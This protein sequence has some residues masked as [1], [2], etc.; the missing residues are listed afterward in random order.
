MRVNSTPNL[1]LCTLIQKITH[2]KTSKS[3]CFGAGF[4]KN[5]QK[6]VEKNIRN[7]NFGSTNKVFLCITGLKKKF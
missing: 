4:R 5:S 3:L 1:L 7:S 2:T 6:R